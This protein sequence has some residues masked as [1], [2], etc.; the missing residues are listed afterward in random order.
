MK[1]LLERI[2]NKLN[3]QGGFLK[4]ISILVGGT[5]FAQAVTVLSLPILT[6]LYNPSEFS[7]FAVYTSLLAVLAAISC[8]RFEIAIPIAKDEEEAFTLVLLSLISNF[9]IN[10]LITAFIF[11]FYT[12]IILF[13]RLE[14]VGSLIWLIPIGVFFSGIY[15]VFQFWITR[16]KQFKII[17]KTRMVQSVSGASVQIVMGILGFAAI[18]LI[19]GQI[20]KVS[21]GVYRLIREFLF[22]TKS[23]LKNVSLKKLKAIFEKYDQFPKYSTFEA[24]ANSA[25]IQLPVI[26]IAAL[27][28]GPEAG[29]LMLAMQVMMIPM[30]FI[31][32]S[33]SQVYLAHAPEKY[34]SGVLEKY[35]KECILQL[36]KIGIIPLTVISI[37]APIVFPILFGNDWQRA[38]DILLWLLPWFVMQLIVSPVS[39]SLYILNKQKQALVLQL[40][41]FFIRIGLVLYASVSFSDYIL[42]IYALSGFI[43]YTLYFFTVIYFLKKSTKDFSKKEKREF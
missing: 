22:E 18:G 32:N 30:Q 43:F 27:S 40:I 20:V 38:G 23:F 5:V 24:L 26:I 28:A 39:M 9:F 1:S 15:N 14:S 13:L 37:L 31:G 35:T 12:D 36:L 21:A 17:A 16:K 33:V 25:G 42:E 29:Y 4:S 3:D 10:I 2:N 34:Q 7:I 41:G 8:L 6:R 19:F 11:L